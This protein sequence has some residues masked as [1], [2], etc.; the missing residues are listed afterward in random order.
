[1]VGYFSKF[2]EVT[3]VS[4]NSNKN[5]AVV[6]FET[7]ANAKSAYMCK[8]PVLGE[9]GIQLVYN[10][11]AVFQGQPAAEEQKGVHGSSAPKAPV[12][13]NLTFESEEAKKQR[14]A[15]QKKR[16]LKQQRKEMIMKENDEIL[17][18]VKEL[19]TDLSE[20]KQQELKDRIAS[21]KASMNQKLKEQEEEKKKEIEA[22]KK[23]ITSNKY[24]SEKVKQKIIHTK[25]FELTLKITDE[26]L[27][28]KSG[29][30]LEKIKPLSTNISD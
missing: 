21:L 18:L 13:S 20:E 22:K 27:H 30:V 19:N 11:G 6:R 24:V 28:K 15:I 9:P 17:K 1:L 10:P 23:S 12:G 7:P 16:I 26:S 2:G 8:E 29:K 14:E 4:V 5:T 3:N 25:W